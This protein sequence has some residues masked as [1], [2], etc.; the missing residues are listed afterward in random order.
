MKLL[1]HYA[2]IYPVVHHA[3]ENWS[4]F[5]L[6]ENTVYSCRNT[7]YNDVTFPSELHY[8]DYFEVVFYEGGDVEYVCETSLFKLNYGDVVI[9]PPGKLHMSKIYSKFTN[10]VRHVF[11]IYPSAFSFTGQ[12]ALS[13]FIKSF[14]SGT[15]LTFTDRE[16]KQACF[17]ALK[18]LCD[19]LIEDDDYQKSLALAYFLEVF[20][21]V[22]KKTTSNSETHFILPE[23]LLAVKD[24]IDSHLESVSTVSDVASKFFYSREYLSRSFKKHFN[25]TVAEYV[26]NKRIQLSQTLLK[27]NKSITETAFAVGYGSLSTY[28]RV[29]KKIVGL[30]PSNYIKLVNSI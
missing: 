4:D 9:I 1:S 29:F 2:N 8:H 3:T 14:E 16:S 6:N 15:I 11:Y 26:N 19:T 28:I 7:V 20:C 13:T 30:T 27:Q 23:K 17:D 25:T 21:L 10:Y 18:K 5:S 12:T 24:Y 22:A